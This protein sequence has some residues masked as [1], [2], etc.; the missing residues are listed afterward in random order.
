MKDSKMIPIMKKYNRE[1]VYQAVA[2]YVNPSSDQARMTT[3]TGPNF[4]IIKTEVLV[5]RKKKDIGEW[6]EACVV[7]LTFSESSCYVNVNLLTTQDKGAMIGTVSAIGTLAAGM[8]LGIAFLPLVAGGAAVAAGAA[9]NKAVKTSLKRFSKDI[10]DIVEGYLCVTG[11]QENKIIQE[12]GVS[13]R[14]CEC[15][16]VLQDGIK[17]CP[18]CG[19]KAEDSQPG[20]RKCECGAVLQDGAKFCGVC[21]KKVEERPQEMVCACGNILQKGVRFCPECGKEAAG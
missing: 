16:A 6:M 8:A 2:T 9:S 13:E 7:K 4:Y 15:G 18:V 19:K 21:G 20:E 5:K 11:I 12:T 17:F 1:E 10:Y 14:K 3:E